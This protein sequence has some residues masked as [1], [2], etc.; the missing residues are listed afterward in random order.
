MIETHHTVQ[1]HPTKLRSGQ[2]AGPGQQSSSFNLRRSAAAFA[3]E[4]GF[5][6]RGDGKAGGFK[7]A[8]NGDRVCESNE[9]SGKLKLRRFLYRV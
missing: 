1:D 7:F 4:S 3:S 5:G 2:E 6:V 9:V 8:P